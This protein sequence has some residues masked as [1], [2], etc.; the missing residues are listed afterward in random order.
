MGMDA[1]GGPAG[2]N[3]PGQGSVTPV[4]LNLTSSK[5]GENVGNY[6]PGVD[7]GLAER[8]RI[9]GDHV[10]GSAE[11]RFVPCQNLTG[12]RLDEIGRSM[13]LRR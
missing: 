10:V 4:H 3:G 13:H 7:Q 1:A 6:L 8:D 12:L 9:T 11:F 5:A 2:T